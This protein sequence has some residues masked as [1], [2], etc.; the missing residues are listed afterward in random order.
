[1]IECLDFNNIAKIAYILQ[2]C[3]SNDS[4]CLISTKNE[5]PTPMGGD[6]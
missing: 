4:N 3:N 2:K 6:S 1:M 5:S